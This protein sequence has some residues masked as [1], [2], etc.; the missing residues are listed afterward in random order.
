MA[1]KNR[2]ARATTRR[3]KEFSPS[4]IDL[5]PQDGLLTAWVEPSAVADQPTDL[6]TENPVPG[7]AEPATNPIAAFNR[8][9]RVAERITM[10]LS[11]L[12]VFGTIGYL[13]LRA[14]A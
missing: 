3:L 12:L 8:V 6:A 7:S 1:K 11:I 5:T 4:T 2:D 10:S 9:W 14:L 13:S